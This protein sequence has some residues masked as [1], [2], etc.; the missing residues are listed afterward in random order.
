MRGCAKPAEASVIAELFSGARLAF[1]YKEVLPEVLARVTSRAVEGPRGPDVVHRVKVLREWLTAGEVIELELPRNLSCAACGGGG[2]DACGR[3]GAITLRDREELA[4]VV[5]VT[6]P[7][8]T[9]DQLEEA[10]GLTLRIPEQGGLSEPGS[11]LPRGTL[12]LTLIP[13]PKCD[14]RVRLLRG[15]VSKRGL[16]A[17]AGTA[18]ASVSSR[19]RKSRLSPLGLVVLAALV[20]GASLLIWLKLSG[21][22]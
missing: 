11:D 18:D 13:S 10:Q 16:A 20:L 8:R 7:V 5:E 1:G 2:C 17:G 15:S 14:P 22:R 12:L 9:P 6:L 3:S 4:E 19:A 21:K